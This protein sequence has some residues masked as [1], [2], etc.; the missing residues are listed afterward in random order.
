ME[1]VRIEV[2][3]AHY[4]EMRAFGWHAIHVLCNANTLVILLVLPAKKR[5][6]C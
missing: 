5:D 2:P 3:V 1:V 6:L 4:L